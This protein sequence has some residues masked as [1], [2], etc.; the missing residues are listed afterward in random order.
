MIYLQFET[1]PNHDGNG[2]R[3]FQALVGIRPYNKTAADEDDDLIIPDLVIQQSALSK[4]V[5]F[6]ERVLIGT[7]IFGVIAF[8]IKKTYCV[9]L[10]EC[11]GSDKLTCKT[12]SKEG[13]QQD[14]KKQE[15]QDLEKVTMTEE[16][17]KIKRLKMIANEAE[18]NFDELDEYGDDDID[19][20]ETDD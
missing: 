9:K 19:G 16:W 18:A 12:G 15:D 14:H 5:T 3:Y 6:N 2:N 7:F 20:N 17:K 11:L 10:D 1:D 4:Q 8:C 13:S